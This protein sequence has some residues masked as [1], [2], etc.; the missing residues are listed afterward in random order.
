MIDILKR[1]DKKIGESTVDI[2]AIKVD[3]KSVRLRLNNVEKNIGT[4]ADNVGMIKDDV[5]NMKKS[6]DDLSEMTSE[7]LANMIIL[8][9]FKTLSQRVSSLEQQ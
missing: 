2:H 8:K 9:E 7:I 4:L 1:L 5:K 3:M 6:I